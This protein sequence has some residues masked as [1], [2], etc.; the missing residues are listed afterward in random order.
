MLPLKGIRPAVSSSKGHAKSALV[1]IEGDPSANDRALEGLRMS[2]GLTLAVQHVTVVLEGPAA[3]LLRTGAPGA[4]V[5]LD[6]LAR[7]GAR[8]TA[9]P[10]PAEG[11]R[12]ADAVIRWDG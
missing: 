1:V 12:S 7:Q 6:A 9:G 11:L 5:Y 3:A 4:R 8:V 10:W 2:V